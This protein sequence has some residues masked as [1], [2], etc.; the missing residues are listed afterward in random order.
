MMLEIADVL[1]HHHV[2]VHRKCNGVLQ[3]AAD[4]ENRIQ[5]G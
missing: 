3:I 2:A 4:S 5:G 1:A